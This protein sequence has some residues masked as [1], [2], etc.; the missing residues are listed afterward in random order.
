MEFRTFSLIQQIFTAYYV[1]GNVLGIAN[2]SVNKKKTRIPTLVELLFLM[3]DTSKKYD[4]QVNY[5]ARLKVVSTVEKVEKL[6]D[7]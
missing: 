7:N 3:E 5:T 1:S 2:V 6:Q 4:I